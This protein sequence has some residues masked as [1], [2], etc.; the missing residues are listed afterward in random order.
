MLALADFADRLGALAESGAHRLKVVAIDGHSS[1]GK[2][3][4]SGRLGLLMPGAAVLHTDDIAWHHSLFDWRDLLVDGF[5]TPLRSGADVSYRPPPW[6]ERGRPGAVEIA[7]ATRFLLLEGVGSSRRDLVDLLDAAVWVE[8][9]EPER[10]RRDDGRI[11]AGEITR[12]V[13]DGWMAV[14]NPFL[15]ADRPWRRAD[16]LVAGNSPLPHDR[17]SQIVVRA[18]WA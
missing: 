18:D 1:S 5:L 16:V 17:N 10:L 4:L 12:E 14:E 11:E 2:T 15:A 9:D 6:D 13:Y 7:G 8:T 3:T